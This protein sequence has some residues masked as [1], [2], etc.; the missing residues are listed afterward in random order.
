[1]AKDSDLSRFSVPTGD[2]LSIGSD[3]VIVVDIKEIIVS[4]SEEAERILQ[5]PMAR[6][7]GKRLTDVLGALPEEFSFALRETLEKGAVH[8]NISF[9]LQGTGGTVRR[10]IFSL[11]PLL[12]V[13]RQ[14]AGAVLT[15]RD[16]DEM[17]HLLEEISRKNLEILVERNKLASILNSINDGVFTIDRNW[18]I[19]SI[20]RAAQQIT[21]YSEQEA[22][23]KNCAQL[24]RSDAC[25]YNCP[26]KHTLETGEPPRTWR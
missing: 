24:L 7:T 18:R 2:N 9:P 23:G 20:N 4:F 3:G 8:S 25:E 11:T 26:M 16:I 22:L 17:Q 5:Y 13:Q 12:S 14:I 1:M 21:G 19:T 10:L 6:A 15:F